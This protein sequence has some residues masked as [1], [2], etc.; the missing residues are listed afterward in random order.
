MTTS[1]GDIRA[2]SA[3]VTI[4]AWGVPWVEVSLDGE[5]TLTGAQVLQ[6]DAGVGSAKISQMEPGD[7]AFISFARARAHAAL[8][9]RA[10][11]KQLAIA[12][13][14]HYAKAKLELRVREVDRFL[15]EQR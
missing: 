9:D 4:P 15:K 13:R 11:A 10:E 1:L 14:E 3:R 5:H 8:G 2:T 6:L 12:S 7:L